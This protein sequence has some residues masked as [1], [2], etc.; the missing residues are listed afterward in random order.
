VESRKCYKTTKATLL[1]V[2]FCFLKCFMFA[3]HYGH[4]QDA[5]SSQEIT[6]ARTS[7]GRS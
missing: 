7:G 1:K 5:R 2:A 4:E 6:N 3:Q